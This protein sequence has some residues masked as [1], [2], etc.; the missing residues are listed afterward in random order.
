LKIGAGKFL[1]SVMQLIL[2]FTHYI[3][4]LKNLIMHMW[5]HM[6]TPI[7]IHFIYSGNKEIHW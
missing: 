3:W 5:T 2:G 4:P 1:A 7:E 6:K